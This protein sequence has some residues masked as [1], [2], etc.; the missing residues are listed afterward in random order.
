MPVH[1]LNADGGGSSTARDQSWPVCRA[2]NVHCVHA[3]HQTTL[4]A[5][6]FAE[7]TGD[8]DTGEGRFGAASPCVPHRALFHLRFLCRQSCASC[9][10]RRRYPRIDGLAT[11]IYG[12]GIRIPPIRLV[13]SG[14]L[15]TTQC[16]YCSQTFAA[17][18][19]VAVT[20]TQ[21]QFTQDG[22]V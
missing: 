6:V 17:T 13:R 14:E 2:L 22:A 21:I 3:L 4:M 1:R 10:H 7:K 18:R 15:T 5:G 20:L 12:E 11:D 19:N 8:R 9:R 16:V